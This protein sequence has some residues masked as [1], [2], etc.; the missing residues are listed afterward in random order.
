[1]FFPQ[2]TVNVGVT[3]EPVY[4]CAGIGAI[5]HFDNGAI[6]LNVFV[7]VPLLLPIPVIVTV[8]TPTYILLL[9]VTV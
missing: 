4:C 8:A 1:M 9:N 3:G 2:V 7:I 6:I 5:V